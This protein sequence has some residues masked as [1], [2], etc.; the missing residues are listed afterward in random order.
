M[1]D[2]MAGLTVGIVALPLAMAFGIASGLDPAAGIFTAIVAGFLISALGGSR[3][4]IGGPT[5]AFVG[6]VFATVTE[7]H[8][9]GL[10]VCTFLAGIMLILMGVF[11]AGAIIKFIPHPVTMGFTSGIAVIIFASQL[12]DV[13]GLKGKMP[14]DFLEKL[15]VLWSRAAEIH[16]P[17]FIIGFGTLAVIRLW[18][19]SWN[20]IIPGSFGALVLFTLIALAWTKYQGVTFVTIGSKF[21]GIPSSLPAPHLPDVDWSQF[22]QLLSPAFKIAILA[23]IESLLCAVVADGMIGDRHYSNTELVAQGVANIGSALMGGMPATAAIARTATNVRSGGATP[24]AGIVHALVL[25]LIIMVAAPLA[26]G[27]P[28]AVLGGVLFN[29]AINM[30][31]WHTFRRLTRWPKSDAAV[32]LVTF[33]LTV[34]FDLVVAVEFGMVLAAITLIKR[35]ADTTAVSDTAIQP[36][37]DSPAPV[38]DVPLPPG[39]MAY[40]I[41]GTFFF[42]AADMLETALRRAGVLPKVLI[43]RLGRVNAIDLSGINALEDLEEKLRRQGGCVVLSGVHSQPLDALRKAGFID[44]IGEKNVCSNFEMAVARATEIV[45]A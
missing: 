31:E 35:V 4:Q 22:K 14:P 40:R 36:I 29:T 10:V 5:G 7:F 24:V 23:A 15:A 21:G 42:G 25:L 9:S 30:G 32:F 26:S 3:V 11:K 28:L 1:R 45:G 38:A 44:V 20:R 13:F 2:V 6:L 33:V 43:I 12:G 18:P 16:W 41:I 37:D 39:V 19:K 34:V 8:Y 27:V 17:T